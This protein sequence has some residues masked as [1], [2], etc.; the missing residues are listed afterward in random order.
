MG[1]GVLSRWSKY[2]DELDWLVTDHLQSVRCLLV[3]IEATSRTQI[4]H[5][6]FDSGLHSARDDIVGM[7]RRMGNDL[8]A[9]P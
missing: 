8:G 4:V 9:A 3:H 5:L 1:L 6:A 7:L 2:D